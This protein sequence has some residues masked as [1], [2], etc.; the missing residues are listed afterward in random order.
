MKPR[1]S[2]IIPVFN[3]EKMVS[4]AIDSV[5]SQES[6][7]FELIV[8][9]DGSTDGT[10]HVLKS[11]TD[12]I[13]VFWQVNQGPEVARSRGVAAARG[14]Y[15][16]FL[17]SD[18][19]LLPRAL[20]TYERVIRTLDS[21]PLLIGQVTYFQDGHTVAEEPD[22]PG[23]I[24]I[25]RFGDYLATGGGISLY[26][27][28]VVVRKSTLDKAGGLR[29]STATTFHMDVLDM[30]L[31][32]STYGPCVLMQQPKTVAYRFHDTNAVRDLR[33]MIK[34]LSPLMQ[35]ERAG[36][37]PGG[38]SRRF[39]RRACIGH[40]CW[41]SLQHA[42]KGGHPGLAVRLLL[43]YGPMILAAAIEKQKRR[44]HP[45]GLLIRL[46]GN[47]GNSGAVSLP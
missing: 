39:A 35:A 31:R 9:D 22:P 4:Q 14:E 11:Y 8:V 46:P 5:L 19:L 18:D 33:A 13:Q 45:S 3:R 37:Y 15:L 21:P 23:A 28:N 43:R 24:E 41:L 10:P 20:A 27:S 25:L 30:V 12:R 2:V 29:Q 1:F 38:R 34:G 47:S 17:D 40:M 6:A 26:G 44:H 36:R 42:L 32:L 7:D 16:A